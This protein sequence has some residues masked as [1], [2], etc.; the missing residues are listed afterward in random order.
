MS[1]LYRSEAQHMLPV[2]AG[3][4]KYSL[5]VA[6]SLPS[7][8]IMHRMTTGGSLAVLKSASSCILISSPVE[9]RCQVSLLHERQ[10]TGRDI[11]LCAGPVTRD[12][13]AGLAVRGPPA[14]VAAVGHDKAGALAVLQQSIVPDLVT[15]TPVAGLHALLLYP[16]WILGPPSHRVLP[17]DTEHGVTLCARDLARS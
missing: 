10:I 15:E 4:S 2:S 9:Q 11:T 14:I 13:G 7:I 16:F 8:G 12:E 17:V 3:A 6:D 1:L 5:Q